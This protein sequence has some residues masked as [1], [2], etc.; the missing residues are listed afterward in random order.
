MTATPEGGRKAA[1]TNKQRYGDD[2]YVRQ[3]KKGGAVSGIKK[4]FATNPELASRAGVL[5]GQKSRRRKKIEVK[6]E[7]DQKDE[8]AE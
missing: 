1:A 6:S 3:G 4:G 2:F 8:P 7:E 5:G